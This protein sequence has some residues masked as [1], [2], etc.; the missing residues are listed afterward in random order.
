MYAE[1]LIEQE[2]A[3]AAVDVATHTV[4][5]QIHDQI[6]HQRDTDQLNQAVN[7]SFSQ[8]LG[9]DK[10]THVQV[11]KGGEAIEEGADQK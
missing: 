6:Q 11:N 5:D 10:G 2:Y 9:Q 8:E 4:I 1:L 7:A 3:T